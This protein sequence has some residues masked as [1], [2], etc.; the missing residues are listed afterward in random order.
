MKK[1]YNLF[2]LIAFFVPI[3]SSAQT[4]QIG[5]GTTSSYLYGPIYRSAATSTFNFSRYAYVFTAAELNIPA[6]SIITQIE[7]QRG[8]ATGSITG[9]NTFE[10]LLANNA[11]ATLTA[12]T[13][14]S[15]VSAG[16]T[17]VYS[18]T[19]QS[20]SAVS[21]GSWEA[22]PC[23]AFIYTG[24]SLQ[25][26]TDH[27]KNG[28]ASAAIP[29]YYTTATGKAIGFASGAA[30]TG[31]TA[32]NTTYGNNRPNIKISYVPGT[33]C[34][35]APTAG[36]AL[37]AA[38]AICP[39]TPFNLS[40]SGNTLAAGLTY[41]WQ[42]STNGGTSYTN[43][44][45]ATNASYSASQ[46]V[47]SSYQCI[48]T[49]TASGLS[50]T[51]TSV[52]VTTNS[53]ID[54][55]CTS[56]ATS[57]LYT[58]IHNVTLGTMSNTSTCTSV[59]SGAG[60]VASM[61]SNYTS[62]VTPPVM[63]ASANYP[64]SITIGNCG[65]DLT[66]LTKIW[67]DYNQNGL[68]TDAGE[69]V[70][71]SSA[72]S[73]GAHIETGSFTIPTT[74]MTGLTRMRI[75]NMYTS[76][77]TAVLPCGTY[78]Y[79]ETEDYYVNIAPVPTCPQPTALSLTTATTT[80]ADIDWTPGGT[81][82]QWQVQWVPTGQAINSANSQYA[83][84]STTSAYQ[85]TTGLTP[86][87]FYTAYVRGICS[88]GDS[89]Y[90]A[91]VI[92]FNTYG[93]GQYMIWDNECPISNFIDISATGTNLN[94]TDDSEAGVSLPFPLLYQGSL[95]N[96]IT[97]GNNGGIVLGTLAAQ[98]GYTMV[99]GKGL[100]IYAQDMNTPYAA[101][102]VFYKV[103]GTAP[104]RQFI[105]EWKNLAHYFSTLGTD[106][107]T[108]EV[109]IDEA[110]QEIYYVYQDVNHDNV[111]YNN[112]LDA[113]IGVRGTNQNINVSMNNATYLTN[114][115]CAHFYYSNCPKPTNFVVSTLAPED[116]SFAWTAGLA[117]ETNWTIVYGLAGFNPDS[118]SQV[119][120]T[121]TST[122]ASSSL[123]ALTQLTQYDVYIY[124]DCSPTLQSETALF[125]TFLTLPYCSNP[126]AGVMSSDVDSINA[127]W[128][129]TASDTLLYPATGFNLQYGFSGFQLYSSNSTEVAAA[130]IN[131]AD[132]IVD[133]NLLGGGVYQVYVQAVCGSDTSQYIGPFSV[134]MPLSNDSVC[135]AEM[136]TVNGPT[137]VFNNTGATVQL[138]E[139][140]I[141][142]TATGAQT[143]NGWINSTLNGTTWFKFIAPTSGNMRIKC[144]STNNAWNT[145]NGQV[146]VYA[147]VGGCSDFAN[148]TLNSANDNA[149]G[150][151]SVAPNYTICGL[152]PGTTYYIL[153]DGSGTA[154]TYAMKLTSIDLDAGTATPVV[155]VCAGDSVDLFTA[156]TGN[157]A[158]GV[159][160]AQL[161][162]AASGLNGSTF[163][164]AGLAFQTFNFQYRLTDGCAYDSIIG[165]VKIF[166]PSSAGSDGTV[167][168]CRNQPVDLLAGLGGNVDFGG[169]WYN[170]SNVT[171]A[172]SQ[173]NSS[174]IP[175]QYNYVY[176]TG[177]NVCPDDS[178]TVLVNVLSTCNW[179]GLDEL[180]SSSVTLYPNPTTGNLNV[181]LNAIET[182][183][184]VVYDAQGK[185]ILTAN[186]LKN[187]STIDLSAVET[188]I[189][190]VHLNAENASMIQRVIKQ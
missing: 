76:A 64:F 83:L 152:T 175:G 77:I 150:S 29:Y 129:W 138:N 61:Y 55:Y 135:G 105:V 158:N 132:T 20:W 4:V 154:G 114:N 118:T 136:L 24:G 86:N 133:A 134:T 137:Y 97:V 151:N 189:Y 144:T 185:L 65:S 161:A 113:E 146:A 14:W 71:A 51:S 159:W 11:A 90:W 23:N 108:F 73:P 157:Q 155:S 25:V 30:L 178:A 171:I 160:T 117:N 6:G 22:Y 84:V 88:A 143:T 100:Y 5:T 26:M 80:T 3:I 95:I 107:T 181:Q 50:S 47:N 31:A 98:V 78:S 53:F 156:I 34:A 21:P 75:V 164:S 1:F 179:L 48:V 121:I 101:G 49:C 172:Q 125:G 126:S 17:S 173:I 44:T 167:T 177:N 79:G 89:S 69:E 116:V 32:L 142:P 7:W 33:P 13:T 57:A 162:S 110:T 15:A 62:S 148:F 115:S 187:G 180:S 153:F 149:I 42:V 74:A 54:C 145:Y 40:L 131:F 45:G 188:G 130:G 66:N 37:S 19:A 46:T 2:L 124:S 67:I 109:I 9:N 92:N 56:T 52:A 63:A 35:G 122:T 96:D 104:N 174:N 87:S 18:N 10:I 119:L 59:A 16:A 183:N 81:E 70:Y 39:S 182:I 60:S 99:A 72:T 127:A 58:D 140:N 112:G 12:G 93:Q 102:G 120:G 43:I 8:A 170:P 38:T 184:A 176:I 147:N 91:G 163:Q 139:A 28:T 169:Q 103:I 85:I 82:T 190:M 111:L 168:V 166:P 94:L 27:V 106:G 36:T 123:S 141:A 128:S 165:Q 186:N 68:F 41:Q